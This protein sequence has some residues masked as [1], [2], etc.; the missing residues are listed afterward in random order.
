MS[1]NT[2]TGVKGKIFQVILY[3]KDITQAKWAYPYE[4]LVT[5]I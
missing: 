4:Q 5:Y 3:R 1:A 2:I